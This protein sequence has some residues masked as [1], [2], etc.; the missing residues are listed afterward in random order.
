MSTTGER[1]GEGTY[2]CVKCGQKVVLEDDS[3]T[4]PPLP[5]MQGHRVSA[6]AK[7]RSSGHLERTLGAG[8]QGYCWH[9]L[10]DHW[11]DPPQEHEGG[12]CHALAYS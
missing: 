10:R 3:D 6:L 8:P 11:C 2:T 4:L 9:L 7:W 1:P 5:Q 12:L